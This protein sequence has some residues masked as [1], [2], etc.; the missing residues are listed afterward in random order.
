M[1]DGEISQ[2]DI[3]VGE[4]IIRASKQHKSLNEIS[5]E[6]IILNNAGAFF[7]VK[8]GDKKRFEDA[9]YVFLNQLSDIIGTEIHFIEK[10]KNKIKF[11]ENLLAPVVPISTTEIFIPPFGD[12][13]VKVK[14]STADK[15][16]LPLDQEQFAEILESTYGLR[17][18]YQFTT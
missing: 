16:K 7:L 11:I 9:G 14:I 1:K 18:H 10:A 12:R 17:G 5:L 13:E 6:R 4:A 3:D 2:V 15:R 8:K